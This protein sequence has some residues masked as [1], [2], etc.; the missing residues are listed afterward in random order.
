MTAESKAQ[1]EAFLLA[2]EGPFGQPETMT[3]EYGAARRM[4]LAVENFNPIHYD[5]QAA[6]AEGYRGLVAPWPFLWLVF[7]NCSEF[8]IDFPFGKATVHGEDNYEFHEPIIV[9]DQITVKTSIA[10]TSVKQGKAGLMGLLVEKRS[11]Y[12]QKGQLCAALATTAIR[13]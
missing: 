11:F 9:G 8:E 10:D 13:R 12:N 7:F 6:L 2:L 1:M 3:V 5:E 4:A